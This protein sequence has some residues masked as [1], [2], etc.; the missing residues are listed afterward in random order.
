[1]KK[2]GKYY[3]YLFLY[4]FPLFAF[5]QNNLDSLLTVWKNQNLADT[6]RSDAFE[7]YIYQGPFGKEPD[8]AIILAGQ[9][10]DFTKKNGN[11]K[12]MA[13][14][15][16]LKGY[17]LFRV[18]EYTK[19]LE[20]YNAGLKI[21]QEIQY[22]EGIANI[23][24]RTGYVYHDNDDY[25]KAINFYERS[26]EL[27]EEMYDWGGKS[28][29][30]NEFGSIYRMTGDFEKSLKYYQQSLT[31]NDSLDNKFENASIYNNIGNLYLYEKNY[32]KAIEYYQK[33]KA[34][35]ELTANQLGIAA[36]LGGIGEVLLEMEEY[37][38]ALDTLQKSLDISEKINDIQGGIATRFAIADIYSIKKQYSKAIE[39]NKKCLSEAEQIG[40]LGDKEYAYAN[41]YEL[42][43]ALGNVNLALTYQEKM[44]TIS[45]SLQFEETAIKLQQMEFKKQMLA[46][47]LLQVEKDLEI[48]MTHQKEVREKD[49]NRNLAIVIG[50]FF[51]LLAIG[52]YSRWRY[53]NKSRAIIEKERDRSENLLLNILPAEIAE[54]LKEKGEAKARDFDMVSI[55]FT[56]FK[57]F[58]EQS[59]KIS[60]TELIDEINYCFKSFDMICEKYGIEKIKTIGDAYMAAGGLPVP[61]DDA[62]LKTIRAGLEMQAFMHSRM[63]DKKALNE[64][65]FEMRLGIH[66]GPVVAGIVGVKKFQYDIWGDTVN[67][68]SRMES[69]GEV[70]KVNISNATYELVKH[71]ADLSFEYRGKIEAKGK[72]QVEMWFVQPA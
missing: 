3:G 64:M 48:K 65:A 2:R 11:K 10:F 57:G 52:F 70:G 18:G 16:N 60:A 47:S 26:L 54:E 17:S 59:A 32:K 36:A 67:T 38:K 1:M 27:Y 51:L 31:I 22:K 40:D 4:I 69:N 42:Y 45:D 71:T 49:R 62:V 66:T 43:R 68:A 50:L 8:S 25:L 13:N 30:Y 15:L 72:G 5:S 12:G 58:T 6:I 61:S 14:A 39:A 20:N 21:A 44:L 28:D 46:D 19:A 56:D 9:L 34:I 29:I 41:L 55:L 7:N 23:L 37:E 33:A 24:I 63:T 35:D 53:V